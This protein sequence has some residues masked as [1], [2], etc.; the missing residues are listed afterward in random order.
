V[1]FAATN[2][3]VPEMPEFGTG[4]H[5]YVTGLTHD[6]RGLPATDNADAHSKLVRRLCEKI[7]DA[8]ERLTRVEGDLEDGARVGLI[9]YGISAR[10]AAGA[11]RLARER[12]IRLSHL[13]LVTVF[14]FPERAVQEF[15]RDLDRVIVPE[16]N[17]GQICHSVR[18]ALAGAARVERVSRIGGEMIHPD[19]IL[20]A[21]SNRGEPV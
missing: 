5:T 2:G 4:Y 12:G 15:A 14:P 3:K 13:R 8:T 18:E 9:S 7:S 10:S 19:E 1:P 16:L 11:V 20:H 21:V 6:E 17:L